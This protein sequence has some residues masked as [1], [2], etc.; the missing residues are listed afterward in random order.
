MKRRP[1]RVVAW[2]AAVALSAGLA[3][4]C[5]PS[6][7]SSSGAGASA[8]TMGIGAPLQ[9][10]DPYSC[11][12]STRNVLVSVYDTLTRITPNGEF[13]PSL[14]TAWEYETPTRFRL[15]IRDDVKFV[16][17]T[18]LDAAVVKANLDRAAAKPTGVTAQFAENKPKI[19]ATSD[20]K[21][22]IDLDHPDP[23][24]PFLF[25]TCAG[26]I[27]HPDLVAHPTRMANQADGTGP[28]TPDTKASISESTYV[29]AKKAGYWNSDAYP[30][31]KATFSVI[32]DG[33]ARLS[34][35]LS[36]QIDISVAGDFH[37]VSQVEKA[38]KSAIHGNISQFAV[39]LSDREGKLVPALKDVR[40]RQALNYAIDRDAIIKTLFGDEGVATAQILTKGSAGYDA[41]LDDRYPYDPA[42]AKQLLADAGYADGFSLTV[43]TTGVFQFDTFLSAVADYWGKVGVK[44]D[45]KVV[46]TNT[47]LSDKF[48]EKYPA[49]VEPLTVIPPYSSLNRYFGPTAGFNPFKTT[50][51]EL[52]ASMGKAA[53]GDEGAL[54]DVSDRVLDQAWYVGA[55]FNAQY[56]FYDGSKVSGLKMLNSANEPLFYDWKPAS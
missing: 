38:G 18:P 47:Y 39:V 16:D 11:V 54:R 8:V 29:F 15:T 20:S 23:D 30:F 46:D 37:A 48:T 26:M 56:I 28:Y 31:K 21:L 35:L 51:P 17:G 33:N 41:A 5:S 27:A 53:G 25:S 36:G 42:K 12:G 7:S 50:D 44:V 14:A 55:G 3:A 32:P 9:G 52:A 4:G 34:A 2:M 49:F 10:W 45:Q 13:E 40:V 22:S 6:D 19:T 1:T 43:L 24:L